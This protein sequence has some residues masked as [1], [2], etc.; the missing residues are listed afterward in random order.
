MLSVV[1]WE[2]KDPRW[3]GVASQKGK[4][5]A[6]NSSQVADEIVSQVLAAS[7]PFDIDW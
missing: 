6:S 4:M 2:R 7:A 1:A 5:L 3:E